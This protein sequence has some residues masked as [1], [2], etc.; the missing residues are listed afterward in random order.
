M[1]FAQAGKSL[2]RFVSRTKENITLFV[3]KKMNT[4]RMKQRELAKTN[5][6]RNTKQ[7]TRKFLNSLKQVI[8]GG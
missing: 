3:V 7:G 2:K 5:V 6:K 8:K 4:K 1:R